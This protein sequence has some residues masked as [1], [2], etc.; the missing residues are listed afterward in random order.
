MVL[1]SHI[2]FPPLGVFDFAVGRFSRYDFNSL[3]RAG[4]TGTREGIRDQIG[5]PPLGTCTVSLGQPTDR[6]DPFDVPVDPTFP[7]VLNVGPALNLEAP[8]MSVRLQAPSYRGEWEAN[9][10][11]PGGYS[12]DNGAGAA[13][14]GAFRAALTI[15]PMVQWSNKSELASVDRT[16]DLTVTWTGGNPDKEYV[17][18]GGIS[19]SEE[20]AVGFSCTEKASAGR[21][22]I[23]AWVL[24]SLPASATLSLEGT[25]PIPSGLLA[26]G[27]ASF[28]DTGRFT[29]TGL[30]L[31][32][33]AYEQF[34]VSLAA[35]R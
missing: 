16:Q 25:P 7:F 33:F 28:T 14:F 4:Y 11:V 15:P 24:S 27:T 2:D 3:L 21:F 30:D 8:A 18:I 17:L 1:L 29:A 32:V 13:P 10:I 22:T 31:G 5:N 34:T 9:A 26:V 35:Y 20:V 23:P 19:A 12:V 6:E